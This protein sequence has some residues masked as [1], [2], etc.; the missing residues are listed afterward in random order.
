MKQFLKFAL[1]IFSIMLVYYPVLAQSNKAVQTSS[2]E[3]DKV[4][5]I[6][7]H[8]KADKRAQFEKFVHEVFWANAFKLP[9]ADQQVFRH[10][11]IL[12]PVGAEA[13]GTYSYVF[14]MDPIIE[15]GNYNIDDL[16]KK[17]FD[18]SKAAEYG[19]MF[20]ETQAREQTQYQVVQAKYY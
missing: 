5:V 13:D 6:V 19:K 3:G 18:A 1:V 7:N 11:R 2:K 10:T 9:A 12:H 8:V 16:L 20:G 14:L 15:G 17:M 4:W